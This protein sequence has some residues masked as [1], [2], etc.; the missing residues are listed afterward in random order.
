MGWFLNLLEKIGIVE[1]ASEEG[2]EQNSLHLYELQDWLKE[3]EKVI[4]SEH[5]LQEE[6]LSYLNKLKDKRWALECKLDE[7]EKKIRSLGISYKTQDLLNILAEAR[8][9]LDSLQF[10]A[11]ITINSALETG[12]KIEV[13]LDQL[14][15]MIGGSNFA[16]NYSFL[17]PREER[18]EKGTEN[19]LL[20]EINELNQLKEGFEEKVGGSGYGKIAPLNKKV[21]NLETLTEKIKELKEQLKTKKERLQK[22]EEFGR[23]KGQELKEVRESSENQQLK[24]DSVKR[25]R[26]LDNLE[27]NDDEI[28]VFF[29]K[30]KPAMQVFQGIGGR[31]QL[32]EQYLQNPSQSLK[33]DG[34][35]VVVNLFRELKSALASGKIELDSGAANL[36]FEHIDRAE[37]GYLEK[38]RN[39]HFEIK[40]EL[41]HLKETALGKDFKLKLE[42]AK[43]RVEH[44][45]QQIVKI[46]EE[47]EQLEEEINENI[48]LYNRELDL[49]E[50]LVKISLG[51]EVK[52]RV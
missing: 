38:L 4:I 11:E 34:N 25:K 35:L 21:E 37:K 13:K 28:F 26:L 12:A 27:T 23:E 48:A 44:F 19:P 30:L 50:N 52:V 15:R 51:K 32:V 5:Q 36:T 31:S 41:E 17:L 7:W 3:K 43:Y 49:F 39:K 22:A 33:E 47:K 45:Q 20:K 46:K 8:R 24:E 42:E 2:A 10:P 14:K 6:V 29:S 9:L 1:L 18:G 40:E 16:Y